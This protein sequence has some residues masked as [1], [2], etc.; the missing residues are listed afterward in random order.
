[1]K[2]KLP[3]AALIIVCL[4]LVGFT[5]QAQKPPQWEYKIE[6]SPKEK[7]VNQLAAEGW[8]LVAV[9]SEGYGT[10]TSVFVF[11]RQK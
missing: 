1:M 4:L 8:E 3:L 6:Y 2:N 5:Y 7:K 11:R 9:G 10:I